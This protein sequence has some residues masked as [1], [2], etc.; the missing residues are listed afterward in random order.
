MRDAW[1]IGT[2][3]LPLV[4][5][6]IHAGH[7]LR[8]EVAAKIA[9]DGPTRRR[10]E[11]PFT[12]RVT[13][14]GGLPIVVHRSRFEVDLNRPRHRCVYVTPEEAWGLELWGE[15]LTDEQ[16][17]RSRRLHDAFY[18]MLATILDDLAAAGPFVVLD[19]HS[20]NH[21]R[22]GAHE[23]PAP[24]A[25][26]PEVNIGTGTLD[27]DRWAH[28]VDR[29]MDDL[30]RQ[31]VAG[32]Q[33]DVRENV[34]FEGG[35]LSQWVHE[36]YED[37][38]CALAVELKKVFMDEWTGAPD[39]QHLEELTEAVAASVPLLLGELACGRA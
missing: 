3:A 5:T 8:P 1:S 12:D 35:Y 22:D 26:N 11:D 7:D 9:L 6:A 23:P 24:E 38:G 13:A 4:T 20:Y 15:P 14:A 21:R 2:S 28:V 25:D 30:S 17:E 32:H 16:I 29:F 10:E 27:R 37:R 33:L 18:V 36:R 31:V 39:R 34:R 19:L